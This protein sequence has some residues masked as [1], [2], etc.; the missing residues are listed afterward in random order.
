MY[1]DYY[2]AVYRF[3]RVR[4]F[5]ALIEDGII[6]ELIASLEKNTY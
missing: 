4:K 1:Y 3:E 2:M 6:K 5:I